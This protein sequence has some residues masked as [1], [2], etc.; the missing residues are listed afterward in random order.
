MHLRM[1][2]PFAKGR[3]YVY[4]R[5]QALPEAIRRSRLFQMG[6]KDSG[7]G[8]MLFLRRLRPIQ[9][10]ELWTQMRKKFK[11]MHQGRTLL[12]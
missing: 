10:R 3:N 1:G 7:R 6:K 2:M 12:L 11:I 9:E 8:R 5:I 4:Q